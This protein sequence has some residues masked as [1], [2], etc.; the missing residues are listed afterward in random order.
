MKSLINARAAVFGTTALCFIAVAGLLTGCNGP[1]KMDDGNVHTIVLFGGT[2]ECFAAP[3]LTHARPLDE[4]RFF[5]VSLTD[6]ASVKDL[7]SQ[8][9]DDG[10]RTLIV[11]PTIGQPMKL[12]G[13]D[14]VSR[15]TDVLRRKSLDVETE[16]IVRLVRVRQAGELLTEGPQNDYVIDASAGTI[17]FTDTFLRG[18]PESGV[19]LR[20]DFAILADDRHDRPLT[21]VSALN[22]G[23]GEHGVV[24]IAKEASGSYQIQVGCDGHPDDPPKI[25][26]W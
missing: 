5:T 19:E 26:V 11:T 4:I 8:P 9:V 12:L 21:K 13:P 25:V 10:A 18:I 3:Q 22:V 23:P 6:S 14:L 1:I 16:D 24:T 15:L 17:T 20:A 7:N 2:N